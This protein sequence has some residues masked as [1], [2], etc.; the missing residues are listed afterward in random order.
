MK[1]IDYYSG[2]GEFDAEINN[3]LI[4]LNEVC[5]DK[6]DIRRYARRILN[7][8]NKIMSLPIQSSLESIEYLRSKRKFSR[9]SSKIKKL[10]KKV[11]A[12]DASVFSEAAQLLS[13]KNLS[14]YLSLTGEEF[15]SDD[16]FFERYFKNGWSSEQISRNLSSDISGIFIRLSNKINI[17]DISNCDDTSSDDEIIDEI[18][19]RVDEQISV[20][21]ETIENNTLDYSSIDLSSSNQEL[22]IE[23]IDGDFDSLN[24]SKTVTSEKKE[25]TFDLDENLG[26]SEI[27][28]LTL[29]ELKQLK[30]EIDNNE[31]LFVE[32]ENIDEKQKRII[33][34]YIQICDM[35]RSI[36]KSIALISE[37][38]SIDSIMDLYRK[39]YSLAGKFCSEMFEQIIGISKVGSYNVSSPTPHLEEKYL[40]NK[41]VINVFGL[42]DVFL[43]KIQNYIKTLKE[44]Q[45]HDLSEDDYK[46]LYNELWDKYKLEGVYPAA[47][48]EAISYDIMEFI[49]QNPYT[50]LQT[51]TFDIRSNT[52]FKKY[53][54]LILLDY[55]VPDLESFTL[56]LSQC[57]CD[58]ISNSKSLTDCE[59]SEII[60]NI[61]N[62][63]AKHYANNHGAL[64]LPSAAY[65]HA[66]LQVKNEIYTNA[67]DRQDLSLEREQTIQNVY[68]EEK[69]EYASLSFSQKFFGKIF[70][71]VEKPNENQIKDEINSFDEKISSINK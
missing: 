14:T 25:D 66:I 5:K 20:I 13:E 39:I 55:I 59:K 9:Y 18:I 32:L 11:K 17:N 37:N 12:F 4:A 51:L 38:T 62:T 47:I 69:E 68:N 7:L 1:Y 50:L 23:E 56:E 30:K 43:A 8:Y 26:F 45:P 53:D 48:K 2:H 3:Y 63:F 15:I 44:K 27:R 28:L 35:C 42:S 16:S 33:D 29:I 65:D 31:K 57:L 36:D 71:T 49:N 21:E 60:D 10:I 6:R 41:D 67:G 46:N 54:L 58:N 40:V 61:K 52:C 64:E 22:N 24:E 70:G 19:S 34:S